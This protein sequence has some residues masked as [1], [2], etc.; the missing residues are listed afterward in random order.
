MSDR[1]RSLSVT[2]KL[3]PRQAVAAMRALEVAGAEGIDDR[4]YRVRERVM[5]GL[6]DAGWTYDETGDEAWHH[7]GSPAIPDRV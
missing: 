6:W 5:F 1:M 3:T 4:A 2:V 7:D